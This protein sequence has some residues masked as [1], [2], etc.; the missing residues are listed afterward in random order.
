MQ[1]HYTG[2]AFSVF[3]AGT[4]VGIESVDMSGLRSAVSP[5]ESIAQCARV[6]V[7]DVFGTA[8][9]RSLALFREFRPMV[10]A[11]GPTE[12]SITRSGVG[13]RGTQRVFAAVRPSTH[14]LGGFLDLSHRVDDERFSSVDPYTKRLFIHK[15]R[16]STVRQLDDEFRGWLQDAYRVGAGRHLYAEPIR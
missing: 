4:G 5:Q 16:L 8:N 2:V 3:D 15:P 1:H 6:S 13:F 14:G 9:D 10:D 12:L 11:I 7:D